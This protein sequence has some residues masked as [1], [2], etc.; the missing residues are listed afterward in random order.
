MTS[1]QAVSNEYDVRIRRAEKL[2]AEKSSASELLLFYRR[3]ASFQKTSVP[4]PYPLKISIE[5]F[6]RPFTH[7]SNVFSREKLDIL[8]A[9]RRAWRCRTR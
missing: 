6:E 8:E 4:S 3:I 9:H 5:S 7:H 2:I 1:Q